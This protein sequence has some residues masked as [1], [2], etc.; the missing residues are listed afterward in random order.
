MEAENNNSITDVL[1]KHNKNDRK[2]IRNNNIVLRA[3]FTSIRYLSQENITFRGTEHFES[4][5]LKLLKLRKNEIPQ[6]ESWLHILTDNTRKRHLLSCQIKNEIIEIFSHA[7]LRELI[8]QI[9]G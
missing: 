4:K 9:D 3:M 5:F 8:K 2:P 7:V 1:I 6:L